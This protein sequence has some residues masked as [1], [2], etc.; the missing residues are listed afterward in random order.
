[1]AEE[2]AAATTEVVAV[3][4]TP[5]HVAPTEVVAVVVR[6]T[7]TQRSQHR[8]CTPLGIDQAQA[9]QLSAT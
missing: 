4:Q 3:E 8:L 2:E 5:I 1:V 6:L 9:L 7:T